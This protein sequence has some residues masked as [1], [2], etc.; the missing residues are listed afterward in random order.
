MKNDGVYL[1]VPNK[2]KI[3]PIFHGQISK[4]FNVCGEVCV[5]INHGKYYSVYSGFSL[6][7]KDVRVGRNVTTETV[8]GLSKPE[9]SFQIWV[10]KGDKAIPVDPTKFLKH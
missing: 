8:L 2:S 6:V 1:C 3:H 9:I 4:V 10:R 5:I 7:G